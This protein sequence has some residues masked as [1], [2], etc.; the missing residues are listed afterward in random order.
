MTPSKRVGKPFFLCQAWGA[1]HSSTRLARQPY[2]WNAFGD[3]VKRVHRAVP[4]P[5]GSQS[6]R[7]EDVYK[8]QVAMRRLSLSEE[9]VV[10]IAIALGAPAKAS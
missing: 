9:D 10:D 6:R 3:S 8:R 2:G 4:S 7:S 1:L 5:S